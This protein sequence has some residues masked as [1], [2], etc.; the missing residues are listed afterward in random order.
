M[1]M[2]NR[3]PLA[4]ASKRLIFTV[5][6]GR[7][8]TGFLTRA[9]ALVPKTR[10]LHEPEPSFANVMR[11]VQQDSALATTFLQTEKL[12]QIAK[13]IGANEIY[14][15]SSHLFSKGFLHPLVDLRIVPDL[16]V[17]TRPKREVAI[18]LYRLRTIP[19]RTEAGLRFYLSPDDPGVLP[20]PDWETLH[21]YQLC[22]WYCCEVARRSAAYAAFVQAQGG[23]VV[24]TSL[25]SLQTVAG[26]QRLIAELALPPLRIWQRLQFMRL[27]RQRVN[28]KMAR[29]R[30]LILP[31]DINILEQAVVNRIGEPS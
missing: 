20:L 21:D 14:F 13:S 5:T 17:L 31:E 25:T 8:G 19:G 16:I 6:T 23:R 12:P 7:S 27:R 29:K 10:S 30:P 26:F 15:E 22:Y 28:S 3:A 18:S 9:L 4:L 1:I 24:H 2:N 11:E